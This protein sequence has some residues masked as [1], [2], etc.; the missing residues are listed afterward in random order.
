M[1]WEC[2][3]RQVIPEYPFAKFRYL[4]NVNSKNAR[5]ICGTNTVDVPRLVLSLDRTSTYLGGMGFGG[6]LRTDTK[7]ACV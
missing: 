7:K 1:T 6:D 3:G 2:F 4:V 5:Q